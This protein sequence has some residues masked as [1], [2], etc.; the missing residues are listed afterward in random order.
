M[1]TFG[2]LHVTILVAIALGAIAS[3]WVCKGND[4]LRRPM[5]RT[6][7]SA[8]AVN[9]IIWWTFRY[10]HEGVHVGNLPLQ[11]CDVAVWLAVAAC[12]TDSRLVLEAA[13]FPGLAGAAMALLTPDL[14][15]PWPTYP[16]IYFFLA[17]GG[18]VIAVATAVFGAH[19]KFPPATVWRAF[20]MVL[21]Y[22]A[23]VGTFDRL[24]GA[25]YMYLMRKPTAGSLLDVMGPWP[26]YALSAA[27]AALVLFWLLWLPV[28]QRLQSEYGE[29][30]SIR[31]DRAASAGGSAR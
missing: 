9:E 30:V 1:K 14:F 25:N 12:F 24:S 17:H 7:G 13:Y 8:L 26:W 2:A 4:R 23:A 22:A 16:A 31:G 5:L 15:S 3:V 29:P 11:L 27:A 6:L 21:I 19:R 18:I 28:R 20:A 10:A